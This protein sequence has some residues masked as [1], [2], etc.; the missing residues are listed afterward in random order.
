MLVCEV[1]VVGNDGVELVVVEVWLFI[2]RFLPGVLVL[3]AC[4]AV[5][6]LELAYRDLL[7]I[8]ALVFF[9][10]LSV[11]RVRFDGAWALIVVVEDEE[12]LSPAF[13]LACSSFQFEERAVLP[14]MVLFVCWHGSATTYCATGDDRTVVSKDS[15]S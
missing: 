12:A 15:R 2:L 1:V 10:V 3:F 11:S 8:A 13:S 5:V 6:I 4:L 7:L 9:G 14:S